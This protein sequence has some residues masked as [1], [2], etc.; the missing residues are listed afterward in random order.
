[1]SDTKIDVRRV[2]PELQAY[3]SLLDDAGFTIYLP[4]S[5]QA[6]FFHYSQVVDGQEC[7][8]TVQRSW[9]YRL[10][11]PIE[12]SMPIKPSREAGSA[13]FLDFPAHHPATVEYAQLVARPEN[14]NSVVGTRKNARPWGVGVGYLPA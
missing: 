12:H 5:G 14:R 11:E 4:K 1:M 13:M 3:M 8:G 9:L 10:G 7:F 2:V 6:T